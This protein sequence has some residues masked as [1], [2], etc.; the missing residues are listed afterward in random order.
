MKKTYPQTPPVT[1]PDSNR[2]GDSG[3]IHDFYAAQRALFSYNIIEWRDAASLKESNPLREHVLY[4]P[5]ALKFGWSAPTPEDPRY[6][7]LLPNGEL[8][9]RQGSNELD[10]TAL[11]PPKARFFNP[12]LPFN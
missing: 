4:H 10:D 3:P 6:F 9:I 8:R 7:A 11:I 12:N 2:D 1:L 5:S